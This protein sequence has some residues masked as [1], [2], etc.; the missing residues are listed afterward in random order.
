[1]NLTQEIILAKF[2]KLRSATRL[3]WE[4]FSEIADLRTPNDG[5]RANQTQWVVDRNCKLGEING[6]A[7]TKGYLWRL[8]VIPHIGVEKIENEKLLN[9]TTELAFERIKAAHERWLQRMGGIEDDFKEMGFDTK[10]IEKLRMIVEGV[11]ELFLVT[12]ERS[13]TL[14]PLGLPHAEEK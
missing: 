14:K 12:V 7:E 3:S 8:K 5:K 4:Q 2:D 10:Q 1:M 13:R 11:G 6:L 9:H